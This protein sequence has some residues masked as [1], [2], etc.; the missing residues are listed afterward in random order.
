MKKASN[1]ACPKC[2]T[3]LNFSIEVDNPREDVQLAPTHEKFVLK[4]NNCGF[5]RTEKQLIEYIEQTCC[6]ECKSEKNIEKIEDL[7][8]VG[9]HYIC[10]KCN[11]EFNPW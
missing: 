9:Y 2:G 5:T 10:K 1:N 4:C 3:E 7:S 6:L 11:K 8:K